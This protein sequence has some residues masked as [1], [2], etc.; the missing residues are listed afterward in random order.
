VLN[1]RFQVLVPAPPSGKTAAYVPSKRMFWDRVQS[2][3]WSTRTSVP[4]N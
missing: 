4:K 2:S 3:G 1:W